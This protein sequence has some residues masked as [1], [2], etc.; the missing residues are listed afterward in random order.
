MPNTNLCPQLLS[1]FTFSYAEQDQVNESVPRTGPE[2]KGEHLTL[3]SGH[4]EYLS[5]TRFPESE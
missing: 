5:T 2:P 3:A 1:G 4:R